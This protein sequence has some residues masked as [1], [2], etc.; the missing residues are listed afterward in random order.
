[1]SESGISEPPRDGV[2]EASVA[3]IRLIGKSF[4]EFKSYSVTLKHDDGSQAHL[5]RDLVHVG[6]VVGVLAVD[7]ARDEVVLIR[8]FRL[9]AHL[10]SGRGDLVEIVAGYVDSE[11][12]PAEA[13][14]RECIEEIGVRPTALRELFS[15]MPS[16]GV[17]DE[18][19][20]IFVAAVDAS[21][22]PERAGATHEIEHTRPLRVAI[23]DAIAAL[24]PGQLQSGYLVLALQW[25]ALNRHRVAALLAQT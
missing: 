21:E 8:Q 1:M 25:L 23:D 17:L 16:P 6:H 5:S 10:R 3:D 24:E 19:A 22:V 7:L 18:R 9:A 15:L 20:T 14:I 13:A 4:C 2:A 12:S 11:E